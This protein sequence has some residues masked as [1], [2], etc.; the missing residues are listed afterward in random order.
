MK[1]TIQLKAIQIKLM[2]MIKAV[3]IVVVLLATPALTA[4]VYT[5]VDAKDIAENSQLQGKL[6]QE[7]YFLEQLKRDLDVFQKDYV[8]ANLGGIYFTKKEFKKAVKYLERVGHS[9]ELNKASQVISP[10]SFN[11]GMIYIHGKGSIPKNYVKA[12]EAFTRATWGGNIAASREVYVMCRD[13]EVDAER[14]RAFTIENF[15]YYQQ[16]SGHLLYRSAVANLKFLY[17]CDSEQAYLKPLVD[18]N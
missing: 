7:A 10:A 5:T 15:K 17:L 6:D 14:I 2:N 18:Q 3:S 1:R 11:L 9:W 13:K 8:L 4:D 12:F 16:G